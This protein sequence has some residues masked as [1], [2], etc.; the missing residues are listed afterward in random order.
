MLLR[1]LAE[2][3]DGAGKAALPLFQATVELFYPIKYVETE[4]G[5]A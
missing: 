5:A 3:F 2:K 4:E 1:S